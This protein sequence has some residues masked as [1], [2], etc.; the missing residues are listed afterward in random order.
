MTETSS[1]NSGGQ[2]NAFVYSFCVRQYACVK[3]S[4]LVY[5]CTKQ[6]RPAENAKPPLQVLHANNSCRKS[7]SPAS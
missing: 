5:H 3:V 2:E 1:G 4:Q 7:A 6:R